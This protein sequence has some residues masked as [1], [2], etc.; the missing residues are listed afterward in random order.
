VSLFSRSLETL[1]IQRLDM[2]RG[3]SSKKVKYKGQ[4]LSKFQ[5]DSDSNKKAVQNSKCY[6][7]KI[8]NKN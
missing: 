6:M 3:P 2:Y 5:D 8:I 7:L 1:V 4:V